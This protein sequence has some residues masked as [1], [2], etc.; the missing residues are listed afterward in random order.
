[1]FELQI[2]DAGLYPFV[3]HAFAYTGRGAVGLIEI[4]ADARP[5]R[6]SSYPTMGDP[7]S[8]GVEPFVPPGAVADR[9]RQRR[10]RGG[11]PLGPGQHAGMS[12]SPSAP[13]SPTGDGH[14]DRGVPARPTARS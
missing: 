14:G 6:P 7:F 12:M 3:T 2:P 8:A 9:E 4:D 10:R 1:M 5:R 11:E 13:P